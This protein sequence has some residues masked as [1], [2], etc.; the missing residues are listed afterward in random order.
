MFLCRLKTVSNV[1]PVSENALV[2]WVPDLPNLRYLK[3]WDGKALSDE[4]VPNLLHVHCPKL[5]AIGLYMWY[6]S[7]LIRWH[8]TISVL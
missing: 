3:L 6:V 5:E 2:R 4:R 7:I 1:N 8:D